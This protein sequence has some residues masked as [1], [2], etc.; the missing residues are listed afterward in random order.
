MKVL[1]CGY[2]I[3]FASCQ[4]IIATI[5][6]VSLDYAVYNLGAF[7]VWTWDE[8]RTHLSAPVT[9]DKTLA[10]VFIHYYNCRETGN[11]NPAMVVN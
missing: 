1:Y 9:E 7:C 8:I 6:I 4:Y 3:I 2:F 5:A 11:T 10:D